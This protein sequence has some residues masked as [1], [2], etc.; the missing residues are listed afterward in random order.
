MTSGKR[1]RLGVSLLE[2]SLALGVLVVL[3]G[4]AS[5]LS[6]Q[7][8][9]GVRVTEEN[10]IALAAARGLLAI[11]R[12]KPPPAGEVTVDLDIP[13]AEAKRLQGA[14][15]SAR[16]AP[17]QGGVTSL[18]VAFEWTNAFGTERR[19]VLTTLVRERRD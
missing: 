18:E 19:I 9:V 1:K 12:A 15:A 17:W 7:T 4:A 13:F 10:A 2:L 3:I 16:Y 11:Q 8:A 6:H 14:K 5:M